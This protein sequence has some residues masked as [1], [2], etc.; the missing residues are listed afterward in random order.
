MF[1]EAEALGNMAQG[2]MLLDQAA[3]DCVD[4]YN[5]QRNA[6]FEAQVA[7]A[8]VAVEFTLLPKPIALRERQRR[9]GRPARTAAP[10]QGRS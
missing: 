2:S 8:P 9:H 4:I 6:I 1:E 5:A 7:V 10:A 3:K